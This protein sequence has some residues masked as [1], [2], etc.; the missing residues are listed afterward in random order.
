M[1]SKNPLFG[2]EV[3]TN[4]MDIFFNTKKYSK[5]PAIFNGYNSGF[6]LFFHYAFTHNFTPEKA[7]KTVEIYQIVSLSISTS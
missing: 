3:L 4:F 5:P 6:F 2:S 1:Y 7:I